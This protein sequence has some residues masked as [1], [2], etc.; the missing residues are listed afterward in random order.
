MTRLIWRGQQA[1]AFV[2]AAGG[3]FFWL[4]HGLSKGIQFALAVWLILQI[5]MLFGYWKRRR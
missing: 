4:G 5:P 3:M 1:V 2:A